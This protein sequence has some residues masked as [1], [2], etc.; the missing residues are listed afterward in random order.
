MEAA[1]L[2]VFVGTTGVSKVNRDLGGVDDNL[3]KTAGSAD[4]T[5]GALE[6]TGKRGGK[7]FGVLKKAAGALGGIAVFGGLVAGAKAAVGEFQEARKVGALTT[8]VIRATGGA[9]NVTAKEVGGLAMSISN[10]TAMDDEAIQSGANLLLTFKN[11]RNETGKGRDIFNQATAAAVDLSAA[12]FGSLE[13]TSKQLGK[14][15]NDP[16]KGMTALGKSGVTFSEDQKKAIAALIATGKASDRVRAQQM[17]LKEVQSQVGGAAASQ[18]T[19]MDRLRVTMGNLA[20]AAGTVLVPMLDKGAKF[21]T[22]LL[23]GMIESKGAGGAVIDVFRTT[24]TVIGDVVKTIA[25]VVGWFREHK[26][27]TLA[28]AAAAGV[29]VAAF[30]AMK[31]VAAVQAAI[32]AVTGAMWAMNAAMA[33]N[34]IGLVVVAIAALVAGFVVAYRESETFRAIVDGAFKGVVAAFGWIMGAAQDVFG[35]LKS[36]WPLILAILTG[37]I[38]LAVLGIARH[39]DDIKGTASKA[40]N[41]IK[42]AADTA[43][44]AIK[45]AITTPIGGARDGL[46]SIWGT[47]TA[48]LGRRWDDI[49]GAAGTA[50]RAIKGAIIDPVG[51]AVGFVRDKV[52]DVV[53]WLGDKWDA[54]VVGAKVF[55]KIFGN[56]MSRAFGGV[57]NIVIGFINTIIG[58]LNKI[59]GVDIGKVGKVDVPDRLSVADATKQVVQGHARGG[60]FARTGGIVSSPITL[61]GEEAPL[62]PEFVIPTNP[63]YRGRAQDLLAQAAGAIGLAEGGVVSAFRGA[64]DRTNASP[65]PS[66]ALWEAGI[67]ESGLRNLTYGDRD[68]RGALQVRDATARGMGIDNMNPLQVAMAFLT[69]GY[70]GKGS[71]ISLAAGN[72]QATAGWVAQQTQG[73]AFPHRYDQVREQAMQYMTGNTGDEDSGGILG[74]VKGAVGAVGGALGDLVSKGA[75]FILD[76]LPGIGSLP[77]W[78]KGTGKHVLKQAGSWIKDKVSSLV[79][80]GGGAPGGGGALPSGITDEIKGA[81]AYSRTIGNW[82]FGPGQLFRP[83]G[84]TYHGQG[85]AV[86]F[87]DAGHSATEMRQLYGGLK[88]RYGSHIKELFYDPMGEHVKNGRTVGSPFGG[89]GDHVHLALAGG[90][91]YGGLLGSYAGGTDYV[92]RTG[93]YELHRGEAVTPARQN[94]QREQLDTRAMERL[95]AALEHLADSGHAG[96]IDALADV[97]NERVGY[98]A[99][100]RRATSANPSN[101]RYVV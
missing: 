11:I 44:G 43:W 84:T 41:F 98:G 30:I 20:E 29:L 45:S 82:T 100:Q 75:G 54:M 37:P 21:L 91:T 33:A 101:A 99:G 3:R 60:A 12:G 87:G 93:A 36:H 70:W 14:A 7:S 42:G 85:R 88:D 28:L 26:T 61:M 94:A 24:G 25:S 64:I 5:A 59:P 32:V 52:G 69:R 49:K 48:F 97:V 35:W 2:E 65:K 96:A 22:N 34:P 63:A 67:V 73:S 86:D 40:W 79:G 47:I 66:L 4:K 74:A 83:G 13:S 90:G 27:V 58:A 92:P 57:A 23:G 31:V 8:N 39:W 16:V 50:W 62:H 72:P 6:D 53:G 89:H 78:L 19:P 68:S 51:D 77:D 95:A 81:I 56:T 18:A 15:L 76:K 38:G 10:K 1:R 55:G 80:A 71:A 9:A 46:V 17:I